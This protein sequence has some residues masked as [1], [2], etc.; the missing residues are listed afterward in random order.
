MRRL[1]LALLLGGAAFPS[2]LLAQ[3][4]GLAVLVVDEHSQPIEGAVGEVS[5]LTAVTDEEGMMYFP[6]LG[7][8]RWQLHVRFIGYRPEVREVMVA[9][10]EA[11]RVIVKLEPAPL[12][13]APV[14]VEATRP[15]VFGVVSTNRLEPI[16]NA[17]VQF[18][19]RSGRT[20]RT[21]SAG[22]FMHPD[23]RGPYM[24]R[25][26][27]RG[28][29]ERRFSLS[30]PDEGGREV[31]MTL[32]VAPE[33]YLGASNREHALF[34]DLTRRLAWTNPRQ[35]LT[36]EDLAR[37]GTGSICDAPQIATTV[38]R[39]GRMDVDALIDGEFRVPNPCGLRSHQ[40]QLIEWGPNACAPTAM[41]AME[42]LR[43]RN[44]LMPTASGQAGAVRRRI[45]QC[46][47]YLSVWLAR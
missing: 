10:I 37:F 23:A 25:I 42:L 16:G 6:G 38:A 1:V 19:G 30:V 15:G 3:G 21:D 35:F 29:V 27:A 4:G 46:P 28:F 5:E 33:G 24:V 22:R 44:R 13:L 40:V 39:M 2:G 34:W 20:V 11:V 32:D 18:I 31:L 41:G 43:D 17:E 7:P 47:P 12:Y 36:S 45:G 8:G 14:I 9:G 26:S